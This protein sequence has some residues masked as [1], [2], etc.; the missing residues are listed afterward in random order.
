MEQGASIIIIESGH[1]LITDQNKR[2]VFPFG[3]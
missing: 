1:Q 3:V 2:A